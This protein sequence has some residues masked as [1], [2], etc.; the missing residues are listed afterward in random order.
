[1]TQPNFLIIGAQKAGTSSLYQYLRQHPDIYMSP[2]KEAHFF[3]YLDQKVDFKEPGFFTGKFKYIEDWKTYNAL[4]DEVQNEHAIGEASPSYIYIPETAERIHQHFPDIK[5]IAILRNPAER[6][7]SNFIH[8]RS[9]PKHPETINDLKV[10]LELENQRIQDG[11]SSSW[12][13]KQK[14]FYHQQLER[15]YKLF[16]PEQIKICLF[17]ELHTNP[18]TVLKDIFEFLGVDPNFQADVDTVHNASGIPKNRIIQFVRPCLHKLSGMAK[19]VLPQSTFLKM[20]SKLLT[21]PK[22][23]PKER[24]DLQETFREDT[25]ALQSLIQKDLSHWLK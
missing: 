5:L 6:T 24:S 23:S 21:K 25:E 15:Y 22:L 7:F 12:H 13:Y 14:G 2:V 3:S 19:S 18:Q 16:K 11:W 20:K 8:N 4:F 17:E 1:M 9:L 10:A